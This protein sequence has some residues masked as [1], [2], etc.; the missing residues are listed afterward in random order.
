MAGRRSVRVWNRL[1][2]NE[3]WK[4][5]TSGVWGD[6]STTFFLLLHLSSPRIISLEGIILEPPPVRR[7]LAFCPTL[8]TGR[9]LCHRFAAT[10]CFLAFVH[11]CTLQ[12]PTSAITGVVTRSRFV[13]QKPVALAS[14]WHR[15][16][17]QASNFRPALP[18]RRKDGACSHS[19]PPT[20]GAAGGGEKGVPTP[21]ARV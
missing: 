21:F 14:S 18:I 10:R 3:T 20:G 15:G 19:K 13:G 2:S 1:T 5:P 17:R 7:K 12:R 6:T 8:V 9:N 11:R 16:S 4:P